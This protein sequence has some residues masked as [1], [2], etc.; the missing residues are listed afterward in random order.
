MQFIK[1]K[2][3]SYTVFNQKYQEH[4]HTISGALEEAFQKHVNAVGVENGFHILDFCFGL[5]YNSIAA[6]K[7]HRNLTIIG[8]ENDSEI[9]EA[10]KNL[11]VLDEIEKE[12]TT[13]QN[14]AEKLE[15]TDD[16]NNTIKLIIGEALVSISSL[17]KDY[18]D[19]VFFDPFSPGKQPE[20]WSRKVFQKVRNV[21]KQ[22]AK[23]STY[24]CAKSVRQNMVAVGFKVMD[25]PIVGRKSPATIAVK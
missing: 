24:S 16:N 11:S 23:L 9:I 14:I 5:G 3:G 21:M 1:T 25:G 15:I 17:P 19:R 4:Y 12:F 20:M 6:T 10:I 13:F 8:L 2:D 18:F 22:G 7:D